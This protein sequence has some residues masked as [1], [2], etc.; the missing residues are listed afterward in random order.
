MEILC[1]VEKET[2]QGYHVTLTYI[3]EHKR[4]LSVLFPKNANEAPK[5]EWVPGKFVG[6]DKPERF[7]VWYTFEDRKA[8][9]EN[10]V[11]Y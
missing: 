1:S 11:C 8:F 2:D 10:F 3:K 9:C 5:L 7:G 4:H 6:I